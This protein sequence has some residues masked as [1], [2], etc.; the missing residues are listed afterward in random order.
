[1]ASPLSVALHDSLNADYRTFLARK[2][3]ATVPDIKDVAFSRLLLGVVKKFTGELDT[4]PEGDAAALAKFRASNSRARDWAWVQFDKEDAVID[5]MIRLTLFRWIGHVNLSTMHSDQEAEKLMGPGASR[6]SKTNDVYTKLYD[7]C[8]TASS[9]S[10]Y[11]RYLHQIR[12][13]TAI[14]AES[15]RR[16]VHGEFRETVSS[17]AS[18]AKKSAHESRLITTE[19]TLNMYFQ[20]VIGQYV[21]GLLLR[22][23]KI[24]L[25]TQPGKNRLLARFGS[26]DGRHATIDLSD[27]S[28]Y[29]LALARVLFPS[30]FFKAMEACRTESVEINGDVEPMYVLSGMG[31]GFTFQVETLLFAA[32][33]DTVYRYLGLRP[34]GQRLN[35]FGDDIICH[36]EAVDL[37]VATLTRLGFRVN[38]GKSFVDGPFRESCGGD[39]HHG[40][41]VKPVYIRRLDRDSDIYSAHNRLGVW[42]KIHDIDIGN[43]LRLL[44][45]SARERLYVPCD[46]DVNAGFYASVDNLAKIDQV[47]LRRLYGRQRDMEAAPQ[48]AVFYSYLVSEAVEPDKTGSWNPDGCL[49]AVSSGRV[50]PHSKGGIKTTPKA[51]ILKS[52]KRIGFVAGI[53]P[54]YRAS[55][56]Y[57]DYMSTVGVGVNLHVLLPEWSTV[58]TVCWLPKW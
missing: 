38:E 9:R 13:K 3:L 22:E 7:S 36:A 48:D 23:C 14:S 27:A 1:M 19:P 55:P 56:V 58:R 57:E 33:L 54:S 42:S 47:S 39:Y 31:N 11:I 41:P 21:E 44:R 17:S 50:A 5:E 45:Q 34:E 46:C 15:I 6:G 25:A 43:T 52:R 30:G 28:N 49:K 4:T 37:L 40:Q 53:D 35:V 12:D 18:F 8:L 51:V 2:G 32:I 10:L 16:E 24:D 20:K 29:P 26:I